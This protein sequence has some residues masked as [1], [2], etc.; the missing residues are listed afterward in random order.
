MHSSTRTD[1]VVVFVLV[2]RVLAVQTTQELIRWLSLFFVRRVLAVQNNTGTDQV[3]VFVLYRT[4]SGCA[5][6]HSTQS[7]VFLLH[8][9][10]KRKN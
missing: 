5:Q 1:Q 3:V 6:Q 9:P 4:C 2:R 7:R 8:V 10:C